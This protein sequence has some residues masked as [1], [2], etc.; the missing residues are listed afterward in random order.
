[1]ATQWLCSRQRLARLAYSPFPPSLTTPPFRSYRNESVVLVASHTA[2]VLIDVWDDVDNSSFYAT[3]RDDALAENELLRMLPLVAAARTLGFFI[4]HAPSEGQEW[5][6]IRVLP[7]EVL[8]TG[9]NGSTGSS[10]RCDS[11]ILDSERAIRHVLVAGYDTNKCVVDK[12]CGI[13]SLSTQL[14]AA[15][16]G[17]DT[18]GPEVILLRDVTRGQ[19]PWLGN[20]YYGHSASVNMLELGSWLSDTS[21]TDVATVTSILHHESRSTNYS[22][23]G[24][25]SALLPD[26]M[27]AFGLNS[28]AAQLQPLRFPAPSASQRFPPAGKPC[29]LVAGGVALVVV[30]CSSDYLNDGFRAR[31]LENRHM[32][33]EPL[34]A[35]LRGVPAVA[36]IIHVPNGH[37][38]DGSCAPTP[39]EFVAETTNAFDA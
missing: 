39:G 20:A 30:S 9:I 1:M 32:A 5:R 29:S 36:H 17:R 11:V 12:P 27:A 35:I 13:V 25:R 28:S 24:I 33:L 3:A 16:R 31:V 34:L 7:G 19:Y 10:S 21:P 8:V 38:L 37:D 22:R 6:K 15:A 4:I 2:L 18:G 23:W 26:L 14:T